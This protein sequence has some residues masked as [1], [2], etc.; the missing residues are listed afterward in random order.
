MRQAVWC[1]T[2]RYRLRLRFNSAVARFQ[3]DNGSMRE[4]R[5]METC[6]RRIVCNA[7][8]GTSEI[9]LHL[10]A[11]LCEIIC[12]RPF[13]LRTMILTHEIGCS[14]QSVLPMMLLA[15][16]TCAF[17]Q[18]LPPGI[19]CGAAMSACKTG[20]TSCILLWHC[21]SFT[22]RRKLCGAGGQWQQ[23]ITLLGALLEMKE[24]RV[25]GLLYECFNS[26]FGSIVDA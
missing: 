1:Q 16:P 21:I 18:V 24:R 26:W 7:T 6:S 4:G 25:F 9:A 11:F 19:A 14:F 12:P 5:G 10:F 20:K 2:D 8:T 23:A 13:E 22:A 3:R 17:A 15:V